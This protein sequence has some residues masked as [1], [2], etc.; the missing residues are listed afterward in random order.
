MSEAAPRRNLSSSPG[1]LRDSS[2][3]A[4]STIS[5]LIDAESPSFK[6]ATRPLL[7]ALA[8]DLALT[9]LS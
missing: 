2:V 6:G 9:A 1:K 8:S 5:M 7:I 4:G 3:K